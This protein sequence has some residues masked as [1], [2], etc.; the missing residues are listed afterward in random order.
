VPVHFYRIEFRRL[1]GDDFRTHWKDW[2]PWMR[3]PG[4]PVPVQQPGLGPKLSE[5]WPYPLDYDSEVAAPNNYR[6]LYEDG[7][8]RLVEVAVRPGE[9]TPMHGNP[10][11][12]VLAFNAVGPDKQDIVNTMLDPKASLSG[13]GAGH[14]PAP[15]VFN[16]KEPTCETL[17]PQAPHTIRNNSQIPLHYYRIEFK[18]VDGDDFPTHWREWYPWMKYMQNM[19]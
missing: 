15:T 3:E 16:M 17:A 19:R 14:G 6:V 10:Y 18:R 11:A 7:H 5:G 13:Q 9:T 2:Y 8:V 4:K 1:D 12:S